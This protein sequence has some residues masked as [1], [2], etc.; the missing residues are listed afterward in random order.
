MSKPRMLVTG[1]EG[2]VGSSIRVGLSRLY[3]L[4][5]WDLNRGR[6]IF[7]KEGLV[8]ELKNVD[9]VLHLAGLRGPDCDKEGVTHDDYHKINYK[10][11]CAVIEAMKEA[12]VKKMVF[13][14]SG[15]VYG[16]KYAPL[17]ANLSDKEYAMETPLGYIIQEF[18][19]PITDDSE[20]P[21]DLHPYAQ[22]KLDTEAMLK[23]EAEENG[24]N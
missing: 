17:S 2:W 11:T 23:K 6:D 15:A 8:K 10:G 12:G 3:G 13:I 16:T 1:L 24:L 20:Y 7:D 22:C 14:S 9:A 18:D 5:S 4:V 19:L 21:I